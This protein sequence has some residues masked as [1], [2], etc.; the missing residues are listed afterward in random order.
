M[1]SMNSY[2]LAGAVA[3][4]VTAWMFSDN[5]LGL[6]SSDELDKDEFIKTEENQP[7]VVS[8]VRVKN[9]PISE[10]VRANG[11]TEADF[12][13]TVSTKASG[14]V[15]KVGLAEGDDIQKGDLLIMLDKGTLP[16]QIR[17][18]KA[19]LEVAK[20]RKEVAARLAK[21]N[22]SAPLEQAERAAE[23]QNALV[24]LKVLQ[25]QL[26]DTVINSPV[27]GHLETMH[28]ETGERILINMPAAT[29][30][31]LDTLS[32][33]VAVPQNE[34]SNI[35]IGNP[36]LLLISGVKRRGKVSKISVQSNAGTRTFSVTIDMP[37]K[38]RL[39]R[40]GMSVEATIET[41]MVSAFGVSPAHLSVTK[42]G[43]LIAK[44][45][46]DGIVTNVPVEVVRTSP[47]M[48]FV[49]GLAD[50][51]ILLTVGQ[52]FV[53]EGEAV[54]YNMASAS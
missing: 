42:N 25:K 28:V 54:S 7:F 23:Y 34:I 35:S 45:S 16:D 47:E 39:L 51:T 1:A 26:S 5:M 41:G 40:A 19:D 50:G 10:V 53:S 3:L 44:V 15:I 20:K 27:D 2:F 14:E 36:A 31:G 21:D 32:I 8:A 13:V 11:F 38:D 52:A 6:V 48:V 43:Q 46:L 29:I 24:N 33:I 9:Q 49:S 22:F 17:A 12:E 18:A 37:N 30:L 4:G